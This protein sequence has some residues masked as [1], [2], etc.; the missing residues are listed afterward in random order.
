LQVEK[1]I[2]QYPRAHQLAINSACYLL[3]DEF[4]NL[5]LSGGE[6][7]LIKV[8]DKRTQDS[9]GSFVGH[10]EGVVNLEGKGDGNFFSSNSKDQLVKLWDMRKMISTDDLNKV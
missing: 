10:L 5:I 6:D 3:P 1:E 9:C 4:S 8:W 2:L 7:A